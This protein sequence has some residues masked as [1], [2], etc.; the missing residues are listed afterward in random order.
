MDIADVI[1]QTHPDVVVASNVFRNVPTI[2]QFEDTP[3]I[4]VGRFAEAGFAAKFHIFNQDNQDIAVVVGSRIF[5]TEIGKKCNLRRRSEPNLTA[6]ELEG[7]TILEMRH[8]A[9]AAMNL[10]A[11]LWAPEGILVKSRHSVITSLIQNEPEAITI[12]NNITIAR[13]Y[14]D[15]FHIG[16]YLYRHISGQLAMILG[17]QGIPILSNGIIAGRRITETK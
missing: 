3:L 1:Y 11:E 10:A 8:T 7:K 17:A 5:L 2:L 6:V 15:G 13:N 16:I 12:G 9:A 4:E 14:V